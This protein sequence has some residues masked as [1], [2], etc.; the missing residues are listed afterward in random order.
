MIVELS[1]LAFKQYKRLN[2]PYYS[3]ITAAIDK[4]A[5][6][7]PQGDIVPLKKNP[8]A[9]RL[10]VGPYRLFFTIDNET[11]SIFNIARRGQAYK[12]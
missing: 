10:R 5:L 4:L 1:K 6:N 7:P 12:E 9:Y 3:H 11:I 2:E 8:G